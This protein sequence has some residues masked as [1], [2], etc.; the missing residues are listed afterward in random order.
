MTDEERAATVDERPTR[1][2][3][4]GNCHKCE[5]IV[6]DYGCNIC[7]SK[8]I[9]SLRMQ[10]FEAKARIAELEAVEQAARAQAQCV[11]GRY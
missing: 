1:G 2:A 3:R 10:V 8:V 4:P 5:W 9:D 6:G 11:Q 7:V